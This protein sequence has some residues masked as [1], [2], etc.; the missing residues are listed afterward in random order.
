MFPGQMLQEYCTTGNETEWEADFHFVNHVDGVDLCRYPISGGFIYVHLPL[1]RLVPMLTNK[2]ICKVAKIHKL[3]VSSQSSKADM[4]QNFDSYN[5]INCNLYVSVFQK[6]KT[7]VLEPEAELRPI[8]NLFYNG[9]V[10]QQEAMF[11]P[12][13][14]NDKVIHQVINDFCKDSQ[15]KMLQ[16]AV[17]AICGK[18]IPINQLSRLNAVKNLLSWM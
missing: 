12:E 4:C 8:T 11:P 16:E 1:Q 2:N 3:Q 15:P 5:C 6:T 7:Y 17:C 18:L 14:L 13:P 9:E 10:S